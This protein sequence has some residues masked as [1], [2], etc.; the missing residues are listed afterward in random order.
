MGAPLQRHPLLEKQGL[1]SRYED[2]FIEVSTG[3][4]RVYAAFSERGVSL[5]HPA[6]SADQF[7]T[8]FNAR[9]G[10]IARQDD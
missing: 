7:A 6:E 2:R 9:F 1:G 10:R 8:I 3:G 5:V 4:G